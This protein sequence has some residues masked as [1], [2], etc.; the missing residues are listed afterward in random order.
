MTKC[1]Y[2]KVSGQHGWWLTIN[3]KSVSNFDN[4]SD[5]DDII[6]IS[7]ITKGS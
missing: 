3:G 6:S 4:E 7:V 1:K 2:G 5:V